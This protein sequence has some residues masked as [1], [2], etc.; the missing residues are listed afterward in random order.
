MT[1]SATTRVL[2][3]FGPSKVCAFKGCDRRAPP[4]SDR[5]AG[6]RT[7]KQCRIA[8]CANVVY[9]RQLCV[10]H[11]GKK[12]CQFPGG[13]QATAQG[14]DLCPA[15]GGEI[16]KRFCRIDGC[17][18]QA[19]AKRLC[20]H[21]GGGRLCQYTGCPHHARAGGFC[22]KHKC[23]SPS[24]DDLGPALYLPSSGASSP[25][26]P[27]SVD[28]NAVLSS[29]I[30]HESAD[31]TILDRPNADLSSMHQSS[32]VLPAALTSSPAYSE[33]WALTQSILMLQY[34]WLKQH[35]GLTIPRTPPPVDPLVFVQLT[36]AVLMTP[37]IRAFL[38][39][40][41]P[42]SRLTETTAQ[43][44]DHD[45]GSLASLFADVPSEAPQPIT[46]PSLENTRDRPFK[47]RSSSSSTLSQILDDLPLPPSSPVSNDSFY[48]EQTICANPP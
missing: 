11:G 13:C 5:C 10:R 37:A 35:D 6:H 14:G 20:V 46:P 31:P 12:Q 2:P 39:Q 33:W 22:H 21:H 42:A 17:D 40:R 41:F 47:R 4:D 19:H 3:A 1:P 15:H 48:K 27:V 7:R 32:Q 23:T 28:S 30:E 34:P 18:R 43:Q 24:D 29:T 45:I 38:E 36:Q 44:L 8:G 9:A 26:S 16:I 25:S